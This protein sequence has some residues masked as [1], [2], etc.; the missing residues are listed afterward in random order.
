VLGA[1]SLAGVVGALAGAGVVGAGGAGVFL[2]AGAGVFRAAGAGVVRGAGVAGAL[3]TAGAVVSVLERLTD[4][5]GVL[6]AWAPAAVPAVV[7][8]DARLAALLNR[9]GLWLGL[10]AAAFAG[11]TETLAGLVRGELAVPGVL[12]VPPQPATSSATAIPPPASQADLIGTALLASLFVVNRCC[13]LAGIAGPLLGIERQ[14]PR[15]CRRGRPDTRGAECAYSVRD[16]AVSFNLLN[17][18]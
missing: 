13:R 18:R 8:D 12:P 9:A 16:A 14:W 2:A 17:E 3:R 4:V 7:V 10:A 15:L 1:D 6:A 5:A 11:A